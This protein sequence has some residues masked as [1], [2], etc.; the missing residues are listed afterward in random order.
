MRIFKRTLIHTIRV[1]SLLLPIHPKN[2]GFTA[3]FSPWKKIN[4]DLIV[5]KHKMRNFK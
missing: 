5:R 3:H 4:S 2:Y 1:L